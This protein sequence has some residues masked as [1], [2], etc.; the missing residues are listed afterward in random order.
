MKIGHIYLATAA[1][2]TDADFAELVETLAGLDIAQHVLVGSVSLAR[3]L[4]AARNVTIG[5]IVKAPVMAYCLMPDVDVVHVHEVR[6]GQ[7]GLLLTLTRSIPFVITARDVE[8][9]SRNPL[10][11]SVFHRAAAVVSAATEKDWPIR[12]TAAEALRV[13]HDVQNSHNTPTAGSR[14]SQ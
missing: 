6:S 14:G 3:R 8:K 10:T 13:Y 11:R 7:A 5:P 2:T 9:S 4:A 1:D 12:H